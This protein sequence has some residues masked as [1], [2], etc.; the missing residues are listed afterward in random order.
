MIAGICKFYLAYNNLLLVV[1]AH[2]LL[3]L[4][5]YYTCE[6][7]SSPHCWRLQER[8]GHAIVHA[9]LGHTFTAWDCVFAIVVV[10]HE[11]FCAMAIFVTITLT[12]FERHFRG[13]RTVPM[14]NQRLLLLVL[15]PPAQA[16]TATLRR[17]RVLHRAA[18]PVTV[19]LAPMLGRVQ[20]ALVC[21]VLDADEV[22][23]LNGCGGIAS[24]VGEGGCSA[25]NRVGAGAR[26]G[27]VKVRL[28]EWV[29]GITPALPRLTAF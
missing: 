11:A 20:G 16:L 3:M 1:K 5:Y 2:E 24:T 8:L 4:H 17:A 28:L 25:R 12:V 18:V 7:R 27:S 26:A 15:V 13:M 22:A 10:A 21:F 6:T 19:L 9:L 29:A 23:G 14:I